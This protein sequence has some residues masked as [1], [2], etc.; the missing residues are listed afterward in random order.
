MEEDLVRI[1]ALLLRKVDQGEVV[2]VGA[3]DLAVGDKTHQVQASAAA[4]GV[5]D[6]EV[7]GLVLEEGTVVDGVVDADDFLL[8]DAPGAD[9]EVPHLAVAHHPLGQPDGAPGALDEGVGIVGVEA[10]EIRRIGLLDGVSGRIVAM[11]VAIEDHENNGAVWH[12]DVLVTGFGDR[13]L[14]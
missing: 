6:G 5:L 14:D 8:D 13:G 7:H 3:V 1:E 9:V 4:R 10:V 11:T 2:L 12:G